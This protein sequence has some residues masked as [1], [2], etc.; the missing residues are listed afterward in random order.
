MAKAKKASEYVLVTTSLAAGRGVFGGELVEDKEDVVILAEARNCIS[1][2]ADVKGFLGLA[3][4][5]PSKN[6]RI[7]PAVP[8]LK[9][10]GVTSIAR[11]T[12]EAEMAWKAAPWA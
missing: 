10:Q 4:T 2:S 12:P 8:S 3:S 7:G 5:G 11:C 9:L 6:C 1:W